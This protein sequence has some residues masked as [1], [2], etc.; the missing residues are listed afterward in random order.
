MRVRQHSGTPGTC[1]LPASMTMLPST[2]VGQTSDSARLVAH[3]PLT[4]AEPLEVL[5][6]TIEALF[7]HFLVQVQVL[8]E[9]PRL[10]H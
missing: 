7:Q 4:H 10:H 8:R 6:E 3:L 9:H 2:P 1:L 5:H